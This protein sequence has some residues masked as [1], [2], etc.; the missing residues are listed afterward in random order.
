M[1][2]RLTPFVPGEW[3]HCY[4]RSI[5]KGAVFRESK[6][7]E[8]F[9]ETIYLCNGSEQVRRHD[10]RDPSHA[11][12]FQVNRGEPLVAIGAY[13]L[14]PNHF[15]LLIKEESEKGISKFMHRVGT[16]F[17]KYFNIKND[18]V[19]NVFIKPFRSKH[20]HD[21]LYF[22]KVAQYIHLNPAE[23]YESGWKSGNIRNMDL[24]KKQLER[25]TYSSLADYRGIKRIENLILDQNS[26]ELFESLPPLEEIVD[27][28]AAYYKELS[29]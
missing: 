17:T 28:A 23:I 8:R 22:K 29:I 7:Y 27:E 6:D 9:L 15:H 1:A 21:H 3:Y 25:Y 18:R 16:S 13:C 2:Y 11:D 4:T 14:M 24:L 19:G 20:I 5:D 26:K 10:L 12:F